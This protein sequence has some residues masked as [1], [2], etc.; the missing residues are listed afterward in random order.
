MCPKKIPVVNIVFCV[1]VVVGY[2]LSVF[3]ARTISVQFAWENHLI[4]NTQA[5]ILFLGGCVAA[6]F[7]LA[8]KDKRLRW[9]GWM[10]API[11]FVLF[12]REL[13]WG[14]VLME[15][16]GVNEIT[17]P[18]FSSSVQL[19]YKPV[20]SPILVCVAFF[21][22]AVFFATK[23]FNTFIALFRCRCFP[24]LEI[25]LAVLGG[26]LSTAAEGHAG[27]SLPFDLT[28]E[29]GLVFEE[30]VELFVYFSLFAGQWRVFFGLK[31]CESQGISY[32]IKRPEK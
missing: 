26:V 14:A 29:Q 28:P 30:W 22:V 23:Q 19:W 1:L 25:L 18:W 4:E 13:S 27:F 12:F 2:L 15:P 9:F 21:C 3:V 32:A 6:V 5:V 16:L 8:R 10:L 7:A 20:V 17:G 11:W 31:E 24:V